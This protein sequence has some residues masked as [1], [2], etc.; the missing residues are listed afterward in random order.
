MKI[1]LIGATG[2]VGSA[3]LTELLERGHAVT[4][5]VRTP[6]KL[7]G[8]PGLAVVVA[9]ALDALELVLRQC[10]E[11][12]G[13]AELAARAQ[14]LREQL[15]LDAI[16][17]TRSEEGMTL[18]REAGAVHEPTLAQEVYDVSGAGDTCVATVILALA[19]CRGEPRPASAVTAYRNSFAHAAGRL[20]HRLI[21]SIRA[22]FRRFLR[23]QVTTKTQHRPHL[24]RHRLAQLRQ[25]IE[26]HDRRYYVEARPAL[27]DFDYD[28]LY[29]EL[30]DLEKQFP[31]L[32]TPTSPTQRVG[33]ATT[34]T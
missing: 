33:G 16:L 4:A 1:A 26:E 12:G 32:V 30:V 29:Q 27:S 3:V 22:A 18:Y 13:H 24:Q 23:L 9:D 7:G 28:R 34:S 20:G 31:D 14:A 10:R 19:A 6:A 25:E 2:F 11:Q 17:L 5:L 15:R 8:R 21:S